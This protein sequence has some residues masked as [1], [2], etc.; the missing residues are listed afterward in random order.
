MNAHQKPE[1]TQVGVEL[2]RRIPVEGDHLFSMERARALVHEVVLEKF[3][4]PK[5]EVLS[6]RSL[7][8]FFFSNALNYPEFASSAT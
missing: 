6:F 5:K 2:I 4:K 3:N 7:T 8:D 1:M